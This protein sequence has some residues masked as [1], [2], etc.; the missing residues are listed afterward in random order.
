MASLEHILQAVD[1]LPDEQLRVVCTDIVQAV[2]GQIADRLPRN[3]LWTTGLIAGWVGREV[4]DPNLLRGLQLLAG[5][6]DAQLLDV[7]Y[8]YYDPAG[9]YPQGQKV[10]DDAVRSA[11]ESGTFED[12]DSGDLIKEFEHVL[13]P[14]FVPAPTLEMRK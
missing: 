1:R 11:F 12:P 4:N 7:H 9:L 14:Y 6:A 8:L 3:P 2:A 5:W 13:E 10:S